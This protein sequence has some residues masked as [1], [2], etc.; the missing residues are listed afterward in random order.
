MA[1]HQATGPESTMHATKVAVAQRAARA[2]ILIKDE[3]KALRLCTLQRGR[4][5]PSAG[6]RRKERNPLVIGGVRA[7]SPI[8]LKFDVNDYPA[9]ADCS[10]ARKAWGNK[11][12]RE[13]VLGYYP[14]TGQQSCIFLAS[15]P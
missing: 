6:A 8:C 11:R 10:L 7:S 15:V 2:L 3:C 12:I 14:T 5:Y 9:H 13:T 4:V 1:A